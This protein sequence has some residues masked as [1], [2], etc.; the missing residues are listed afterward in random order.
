MCIDMHDNMGMYRI[1][2]FLSPRKDIGRLRNVKTDLF[3]FAKKQGNFITP[4]LSWNQV[5]QR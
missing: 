3:T 4:L 1:Y 2:F 5:V